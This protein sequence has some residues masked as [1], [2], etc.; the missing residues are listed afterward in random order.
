MSQLGAINRL[1]GSLGDRYEV[2]RELGRGGMA[3]VYLARDLK[4][5]RQVAIKVLHPELAAALGPERFLREIEI[6]ASLNHPHILPLLDSGTMEYGPGVPGPY[7]VM[8]YVEG[9]SLRDRLEREHQLPLEDAIHITGQVAAALDFAHGRGII[10]RDIKPENILLQHGEVV[11]ADFGIARAITEAGGQRLTETGLVAGTPEYMSPEQA[12]GDRSLDGRSDVYSLACVTYELLAGEPPFTGPNPQAV[13]ARR[14]TDPV[15]PLRTV[16]ETVPPHVERAINR[17][18][19]KAPADRWP[20]AGLFGAAL[21]APTEAPT[22]VAAGLAPRWRSRVGWSVGSLLVIA[23]LAGVALRAYSHRSLVV[24]AASVIAILPPIP[25]TPDTGLARL[26]DNLVVTLSTNLN[27]VGGLRAIDPHTVLAQTHERTAEYTLDESAALARRLG[28]SGVVTGTLARDGPNIRFDLGLYDAATAAPLARAFVTGPTED[29]SALTDSATWGLLR[30]VWRSGTAPTPNLAA[31]TTRSIPALRD[32][33]Q[34]EQALVEGRWDAAA[35]AFHSAVQKDS[36]FWLAYFRN[37]YALWWVGEEP[38]SAMLGPLRAH[39]QQLPDPERLLLDAWQM[40]PG[41]DLLDKDQLL[42]ERYPDYWPGWFNR[43]DHLF[44]VG[45]WLG[46]PINDA[47]QAFQ[48]TLDLNPRLMPAWDHMRDV[49]GMMRDPDLYDRVLKAVV[50]LD[51]YKYNGTDST[52][53]QLVDQIWPHLLRGGSFAGPLADQFVAQMQASSGALQDEFAGVMFSQWPAAQVEFAHRMLAGGALPETADALRL[54]LASVWASRGAWD[55]AIT[56]MDAYAV[57]ST[58][59]MA[60]F[61]LYRFAVVGAWVGG[62]DPKLAVVRRPTPG[63]WNRYS[64]EFRVFG[65]WLDGILAVAQHDSVGL[66][67]SWSQLQGVDTA[68]ARSLQ[69]FQL[70]LHGQRRAAAESLYVM[71]YRLSDQ[72]ERTIRMVNRIAAARWLAAEGDPDRAAPLLLW[73]QAAI[74]N[75]SYWYTANSLASVTYL[76]AARVEAARGN[77]AGAR[78]YYQEFLY[79]FDQP[80]P[81]LRHLVEEARAALA[82]LEESPAAN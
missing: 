82:R 47:R 59:S 42:T 64:E 26:G 38:P 76:E 23:G 49:A 46:H 60:R 50:D 58:D 61:D 66:R 13:L 12:A 31:V 52:F 8:P 45:G 48:R 79:R 21:I 43:A 18:L 41:L 20:S 55:S 54:G 68:L 25:T 56:A 9:E 44:H 72:R 6:A 34:G 51:G 63:N 5:N 57:Q 2:Q 24:K 19:A 73:P 67:Q 30:Q 33:L 32:F 71:A 69:A 36:T 40:G 77:A 70:E 15:P 10:H 39:A 16:R 80:V 28:A 1:Q 11:V 4:H 35:N 81:R 62:L 17:A 27:D 22:S 74:G 65:N 78:R 37:A 53:Y 14:L 75:P 3:T 29:I 7:Y